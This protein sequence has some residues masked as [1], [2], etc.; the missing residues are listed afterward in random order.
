MEENNYCLYAHQNLINNKIYIGISKDIKKRWRNKEKGYMH[1]DK[2]YNAFKKYGWNNFSHIIIC[3]GLTK[4]EACKREKAMIFLFKFSGMSYNITD[5]GEGTSGIIRSEEHKQILRERMTGRVVTEETRAK[6]SKTHR[7]LHLTGKKIY[8]FDI[9]TKKLVK[10][11]PTIGDAANDVG[12][13]FSSICRAAKGERPSAGGYIWSYN[14]QIDEDNPRYKSIGRSAPRK[15]YCY[16]LKGNFVREFNNS[17]EAAVS[18][19]GSIK[20]VDAVCS[21]GRISYH[22]YIWRWEMCEIE[23]EVL[24]K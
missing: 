1:C 13:A 6:L 23:P 8:A 24:K 20:G 3:D 16:D 22:H 2:I 12:I 10:E 19:N 11:Y 4:E 15:V 7:E 17:K 9:K 18:V 21:K 5:G 14:P